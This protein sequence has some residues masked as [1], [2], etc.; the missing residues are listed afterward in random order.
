MSYLQDNES[1]TERKIRANGSTALVTPPVYDVALDASKPRYQNGLERPEGFPRFL[2]RL[3]H[4][5]SPVYH[6]ISREP[7]FARYLQIL[8]GTALIIEDNGNTTF[9]SAG[10]CIYLA[11]NLKC[12]LLLG[13]GEH[14]WLTAYWEPKGYFI[15]SVCEPLAIFHL[16]KTSESSKSLTQE[17]SLR[18]GATDD[19]PH[20]LL[21]W[22]NS[23]I[24]DRNSNTIPFKFTRYFGEL[25]DNLQLLLETI[26]TSPQTDWNLARA[27]QVAGYSPFHLSRIFRA[28]LAVGL[29][30]FVEL[31]RT[32][33]A[34]PL[35][36]HSQTPM[37]MI[38]EQCGFGTPQAMRTAIR[39]HTG[40]LPT[41]LRGRG[42][43]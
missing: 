27:A 6:P 14:N 2:H 12:D 35:I 1:G 30:K 28:N 29:P 8:T 20:L 15:P 3:C 13:R 41:E 19:V 17:I 22:I 21:A 42:G 32:E 31:C 7:D 34:I 11:E 23:Q 25:E 4:L 10:S 9:V 36:M 40:F 33:A 18:D 16:D 38:S 5:D 39:E 24:N 37:Q 43:E 26:I